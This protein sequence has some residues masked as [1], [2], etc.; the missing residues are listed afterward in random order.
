M[1]LKKYTK[2]T[3]YEVAALVN[4]GYN[5][6]EIAEQLGCARNTVRAK[7]RKYVDET[8]ESLILPSKSKITPEK[9]IDILEQRRDG[10]PVTD[11]ANE[12]NVTSSCIYKLLK[13]WGVS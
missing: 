9:L 10:I 11:I 8:G 6:T 5:F 1:M 12:Y 7:V 2:V 3:E 4:A 13:R